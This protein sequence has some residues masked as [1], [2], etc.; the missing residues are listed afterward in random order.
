MNTQDESEVRMIDLSTDYYS[1]EMQED[2][3]TRVRLESAAVNR[4]QVEEE[5]ATVRILGSNSQS[6]SESISYVG[7]GRFLC[8]S[9]M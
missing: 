5:T 7:S 8:V 6:G 2:V 9:E 1:I 3:W 4:E